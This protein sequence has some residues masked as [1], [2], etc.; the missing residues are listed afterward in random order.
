MSTNQQTSND[1]LPQDVTEKEKSLEIQ[2][3]KEI[4]YSEIL[5]S[6]RLMDT[7]DAE[8]DAQIKKD[9]NICLV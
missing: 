6:N 7:T 2:E 3:Q 4:K 5:N 1:Q 8:H 9:V